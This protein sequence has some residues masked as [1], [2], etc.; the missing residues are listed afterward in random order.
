MKYFG[1]KERE[2]KIYELL[3]HLIIMVR[4]DRLKKFEEL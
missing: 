3:I 2:I 4:E 1:T